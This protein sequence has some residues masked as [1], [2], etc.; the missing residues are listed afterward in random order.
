MST[1]GANLESGSIGEPV[2]FSEKAE[3]VFHAMPGDSCLSGKLLGPIGQG[4][5]VDGQAQMSFFELTKEVNDCTRIVEN[6]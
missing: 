3:R 1:H 2:E 5:D 4:T 6:R